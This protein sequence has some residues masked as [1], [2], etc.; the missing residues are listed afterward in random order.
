M[1]NGSVTYESVFLAAN[2]T[3]AAGAYGAND[4]FGG[5]LTLSLPLGTMGLNINYVT[6]AAKN[7]VSPALSMFIFNNIPTSLGGDNNAFTF[8]DSALSFV[9][10]ILIPNSN[11]SASIG[12]QYVYYKDFI[13]VKVR[14]SALGKIYVLYKVTNTPTV[15][16]ADDVIVT[17]KGTREVYV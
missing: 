14:P 15:V 10:A 13:N 2:P 11:T 6:V 4:Q 8:A 3:I 16:D 17:I 12:T 7:S 5:L 1:S 9:E